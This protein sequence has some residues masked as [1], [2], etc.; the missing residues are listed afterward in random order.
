[1]TALAAP[2]CGA[3]VLVAVSA[4]G[5]VHGGE[6]PVGVALGLVTLLPL[7]YDVKRIGDLYDAMN[8]VGQQLHMIEYTP[9]PFTSTR[10]GPVFTAGIADTDVFQHPLA[11]QLHL[12]NTYLPS[13]RPFSVLQY[14]VSGGSVRAADRACCAEPA[15][16]SPTPKQT[17]MR[18]VERA[19]TVKRRIRTQ[20][21]PLTGPCT[22]CLREQWACFCCARPPSGRFPRWRSLGGGNAGGLLDFRCVAVPILAGRARSDALGADGPRADRRD[23]GQLRYRFRLSTAKMRSSGLKTLNPRQMT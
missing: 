20:P 21:A 4:H 14:G 7:W 12:A 15:C 19:A 5:H 16:S 10:P 22:A 1:M 8:I 18:G 3:G 9:V 17:S 11:V 2:Q 13:L 6:L 23:A